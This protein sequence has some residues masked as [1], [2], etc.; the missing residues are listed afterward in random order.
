MGKYEMDFEK[1]KKAV[2][3]VI[4][5]FADRGWEEIRVEEIWFETSLP[6]DLILEVINQGILIPSEVNSITHG[7]KVIWKKEEQEI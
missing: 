1:Y 2:E 4:Q 3:K 7:G 6:I 5:R